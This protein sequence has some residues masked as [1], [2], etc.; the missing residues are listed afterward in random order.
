MTQNSFTS[1]SDLL[2]STSLAGSNAAYLESLYDQYLQDANAVTNEW[3]QYFDQLPAVNATSSE[4]SLAPVREH[5]RQLA[6]RPQAAV[7]V[8][9]DILHERKQE[10]VV[11]MI[12]HFR[13]LGHR[14]AKT[15]PLGLMHQDVIE[16]LT[17]A[18]NDLSTHDLA[19]S[20][21]AS[22]FANMGKATL[23]DIHQKLQDI[24]CGSVG[25]EFMHITNAQQRNWVKQ[26]IESGA[27][28]FSA[29]DKQD[30]L[31]RLT[32]AEG[33]EK[34]LGTRYVGQKRFSVEGAESL[35]PMLWELAA[36]SVKH[37]S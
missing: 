30:L 12:N 4:S 34:Y 6:K 20:F 21:N 9:A 17:L 29:Q 26:R 23:G 1:F 10:N 11:R 13:A 15:D 27:G 35:L 36:Q 24:Y 33:L 5:F 25:V 3:R 8:G 37:G 32:A 16:E 19:I 2:A 14:Q 22:A 28:N 18:Y 7:V 31:Q